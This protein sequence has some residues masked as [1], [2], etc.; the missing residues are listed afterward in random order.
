MN[1]HHIPRIGAALLAALCLFVL[2]ACST[3]P[4]ATD[5]SGYGLD[6]TWM[7]TEGTWMET[8][9]S[10]P[11][12]SLHFKGKKLRFK[13]LFGDSGTVEY[14]VR[15]KNADGT[16]IFIE[17]SHKVKRGERMIERR[18]ILEL[19]LHVENGHP[20][21]SEEI[22]EHDG[23]GPMIW[24]EFV[25]KEDFV[26]GFESERKRTLNDRTPTPSMMPQ[27]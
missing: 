26:E 16:T 21:L 11:R 10:L 17:Y 7:E 5:T 27:R 23:R 14:Q 20:I 13:N 19:L 4:G 2:P 9:G 1:M 6:G 8:E 3:L 15:E 24:R 12:A 22:F 25:R 18:E